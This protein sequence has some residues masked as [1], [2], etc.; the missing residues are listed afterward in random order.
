M[1]DKKQ[2]IHIQGFYI[3]AAALITGF[4]GFLAGQ[5]LSTSEEYEPAEIAITDIFPVSQRANKYEIVQEIGHEIE[6]PQYLKNMENLAGDEIATF[7]ITLLNQSD[8]SVN[9]TNATF[10]PTRVDKPLQRLR[11]H[12]IRV[13]RTCMYCGEID[14]RGD[15]PVYFDKLTV[16]TPLQKQLNFVLAPHKPTVLTLWFS[17]KVNR[18]Y[19]PFNVAGILKLYGENGE[20]ISQTVTL[21]LRPEPRAPYEPNNAFISHPVPRLE[22]PP[23]TG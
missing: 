8:K 17:P 9:L 16:G 14:H 5:T 10:I 7:R 18:H 21:K 4:G 1:K 15:I 6:V 19:E 20:S 3:V 11:D 22:G 2:E 23:P 12:G 13:V